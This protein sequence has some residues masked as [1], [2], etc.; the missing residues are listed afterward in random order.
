M[1]K[2]DKVLRYCIILQK[3]RKIWITIS[4]PAY[5]VVDYYVG[6]ADIN[7]IGSNS[8]FS[9]LYNEKCKPKAIIAR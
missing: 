6:T 8:Y 5:P 1:V 2:V 4:S 7:V 3:A 9:T